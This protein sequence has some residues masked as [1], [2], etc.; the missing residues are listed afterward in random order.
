MPEN[1]F[2]R[3]NSRGG[4][5]STEPYQPNQKEAPALARAKGLQS[6]A[7]LEHTPR[8]VRVDATLEDYG[9]GRT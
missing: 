7:S 2:S 4:N 6:R 8:Y 5:L 3:S 1:R 9:P